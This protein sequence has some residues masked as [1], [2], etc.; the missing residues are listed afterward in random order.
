[1]DDLAAF[2]G[3]SRPAGHVDG[4]VISYGA[5]VGSP[6]E[7][8]YFPAGESVLRLVH[9]ERAVGL[10][11]GQRALLLQATDP[12]AF[13]G[14]IGNTGGLHAPFERLARTARMMEKV[15]F[16]QRRE[17]DRVAAHVRAMH[18]QV[19]GVT[20]HAVGPV[21]AG[22]PYAADRPDLLLWILAC[23]ADSALSIYRSFVGPLADP[24][25]RERF[26]EDYL[27][28][29]ELFGLPRE[30]APRDYGAFRDYMRERLK[31]DDLFV[32]EDACELARR[33]AFKLPLPARRRPVLPAVNLAV[34]GTLPARVRRLY[35]I[36]WTPAH[37]AAF[38]TLAVG[39]RLSRPLLPHDVRRGRSA[40]D[41][42]LVARAERARTRRP[43]TA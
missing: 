16:G 1:M 18:A 25:H 33:V 30:C 22:T 17:A 40:R 12:L 26:W 23:L 20:E 32:T 10:L 11:Y 9:G 28:L 35:R 3:F 34:V 42:A 43:A 31:S 41:Y 5:R 2:A 15:Y 39:S 8:G 21:P 37:D 7:S 29:G 38:H 19:R 13:T 36:A 4:R 6:Q 27:L 24:A 14:L